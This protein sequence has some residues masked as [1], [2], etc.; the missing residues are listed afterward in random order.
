M[1]VDSRFAMSV[2][3]YPAAWIGLT[4]VKTRDNR[5]P[6]LD[7]SQSPA[8]S[9]PLRS[10]SRKNFEM[11]SRKSNQ[12]SLA[13]ADLNGMRLTLAPA[14]ACAE[15]HKRTLSTDCSLTRRA[16]GLAIGSLLLAGCFSL[17]LV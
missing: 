4:Q 6:S 3:N 1:V 14:V 5:S 12:T 15:P 11:S 8:G 10:G 16:L 2:G 9:P 17:L 13:A 7:A